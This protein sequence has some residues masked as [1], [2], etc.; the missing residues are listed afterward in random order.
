MALSVLGSGLGAASPHAYY[1]CDGNGNVTYLISTN[2]GV[3]ARYL[4]DA[5]G[6]ILSQSGPLADANVYRFSSMEFHINSGLCYYLYRFYDPGLQRWINRDPVEEDGGINLYGY[7]GNNPINVVD[8][9]GLWQYYGNWGGPDWTGGQVGNWNDIDQSKVLLPRDK[10]DACYMEHD[11]CYGTCRQN[12][13]KFCEAFGDARGTGPA[14]RSRTVEA[15]CFEDCDRAL[16]RCLKNLG[17]DPSN[18]WHAK[19]GGFYFAHSHPSAE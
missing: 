8:P 19:L 17:K 9:L 13:N 6:N 7:V 4:Y 15:K 10:Q 18:N 1:Y 11:K 16:S 5:F 3:A 2:Q 12:K 14:R